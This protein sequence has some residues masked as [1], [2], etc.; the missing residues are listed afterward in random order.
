MINFLNKKGITV[1]DIIHMSLG[2]LPL[3]IF[4]GVGIYGLVGSLL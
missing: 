1:K 2:I 3:A 4:V